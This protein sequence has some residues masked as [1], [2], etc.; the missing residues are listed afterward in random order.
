M[1]LPPTTTVRTK[2]SGIFDGIPDGFGAKLAFNAN[3]SLQVWEKKVKPL[4]VDGGDA[5]E[6]ST[7]W[8]ANTRTFS[9]RVLHKF[10]DIT[11]EAGYN[12]DCYAGILALVNVEGSI[13]VY[14]PTGDKLDFYGYLK[15]FEDSDLTESEKPMATLTIAL[16]N[17]D[18]DGNEVPPVYTAV[19][20]TG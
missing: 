6:Q 11:I 2:P 10:D 3:P 9:A 20:G 5:V 15:K 1:S 4:T 7:N 8:N 19:S 14:W 16:T 12:P 18:A 17:R 13:T